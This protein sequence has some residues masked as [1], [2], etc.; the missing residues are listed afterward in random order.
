M[1]IRERQKTTAPIAAS[2]F[3][4]LEVL[5]TMAIVGILVG[6]AVPSTAR[7]LNNQR[8]A[9]A[10]RTV[11][12]DMQS[13]KMAAIKEN[14]SVTVQRTSSTEYTYSFVDGFGNTH[15]FVRNL[16]DDCPGVTITLTGTTPVRFLGS[17]IRQPG[18]N[19]T[20]A[21][22]NSSGTRNFLVAWTGTI[23]GITTP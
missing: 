19:T 5:V 20:V 17:G 1:K 14:Q 11:W 18:E 22:A 23:G 16:A 4:I 13:A 15:S 21:L 10:A 8:L 7:F 3:T 12:S 2:G 9:S 6:L